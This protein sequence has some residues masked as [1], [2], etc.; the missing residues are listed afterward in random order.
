MGTESPQHAGLAAACQFR[1]IGPFYE[2]EQKCNTVNLSRPPETHD[3][4][5][6]I[7]VVT[8]ATLLA[9]VSRST[10][11][12]YRYKLDYRTWFLGGMLPQN[13]LNAARNPV[14]TAVQSRYFA[15]MNGRQDSGWISYD[16]EGALC[17]EYRL[18]AGTPDEKCSF[19]L[20]RLCSRDRYRQLPSSARLYVRFARVP[21]LPPTRLR[22]NS[23]PWRQRKGFPSKD[24]NISEGKA[25]ATRREISWRAC[26]AC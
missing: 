10:T 2:A 22:A 20:P 12:T 8:L 18:G 24:C 4:C 17:S 13:V 3:L 11:G 6:L 15:D 23:K 5:G 14:S 26:G 19:I 16:P 9:P 25:P 7:I 21:W 1:G